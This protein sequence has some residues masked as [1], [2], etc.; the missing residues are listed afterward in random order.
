MPFDVTLDLPPSEAAAPQ[1]LRPELA[2]LLYSRQN[3]HLL[4]K[5][6]VHTGVDGSCSL[7]A[8]QALSTAD[9]GYLMQFLSGLDLQLTQATTLAV[10]VNSLIWWV[11]PAERPV[12]FDA[13][14]QA[15]ASIA[16]LSGQP[17]PWPGLVMR[18]S[19]GRLQVFALQGQERPTAQTPLM[20][21]PFWNLFAQGVVCRGSV[22]YPAACTPSLQEAW[23]TVFFQSVFTG[24]SR[25][26]R[27]MNWGAGYEALLDQ[28]QRLGHFPDEVLM[29]AGLTLQAFSRT[30]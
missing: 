22:Q 11:P 15:T 4:L 1:P 12:W 16:R 27:Y 30:Y 20:H 19:A 28:A 9:H 25:T 29:D 17:V 24:P 21:A 2:L 13:K 18:A 10:G 14:Y 7:G 5:H 3:A 26:D 8:G 23:E 6:P